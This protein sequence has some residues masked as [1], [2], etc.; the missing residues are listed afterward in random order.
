MQLVDLLGV[1]KLQLHKLQ[2]DMICKVNS[3]KNVYL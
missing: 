1:T 3:M 2:F